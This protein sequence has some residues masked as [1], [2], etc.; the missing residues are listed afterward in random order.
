MKTADV[1]YSQQDVEQAEIYYLKVLEDNPDYV[2]ALERLGDI[3]LLK[4]KILQ[5]KEVEYYED[6]YEYYTKAISITEQFPKS[7]DQDR[8]DLRDMRKRKERAWDPYFPGC[9]QRKRSRKY[10]ARNGNL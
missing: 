10:A 1:Y 8:I 4:L 9:K 5:A 7:T 6:A 2:I 3:S